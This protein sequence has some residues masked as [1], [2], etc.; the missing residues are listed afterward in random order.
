MRRIFD[1]EAEAFRDHWGRREWTD[2]IFAELPG[3]S[4]TWTLDLWRVAWDGDE[5]AGVVT[6]FVFAEENATLGLSRGWLEHVSVRRPWRR[7]GLASALDP[8]GL[9]R[10][11]ASAGSPR[12]RSAWTRRA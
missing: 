4:R 1:A 8:V 9:R 5:V 2:Q 10:R 3:G 7:R 6:T 11:S 12:P